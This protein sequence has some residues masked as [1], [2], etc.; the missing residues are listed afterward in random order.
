V[1][2][3]ANF[4]LLPAGFTFNPG[5]KLADKHMSRLL[6]ERMRHLPWAD[7]PGFVSVPN[8]AAYSPLFYL[9]AAAGLGAGRAA[10]LL[11]YDAIL[12]A[13]LVNALMFVAAGTVAL[14]LARRGRRLMFVALTLP[15]TLSLAASVNQDGLVIASSVLAA[16]LLSRGPRHGRSWWL[17]CVALAA[18]IL[19][20]P[21]YL[22]VAA[23]CAV[24]AW[25]TAPGRR[26]QIR[27][28]G[29]LLV[30]ALPALVWTAIVTRW[31]AAP[32]VRGPA[33]PAGPLWSGPA[34]T[35]FPTTNPGEQ[36]GILLAHPRLFGTLPFETLAGDLRWFG[37]STLGILG[38]LDWV[39]PEWMY[40]AWGLAVL[41]AL[42]ADGLGTPDE[43][44][45]LPLW[46]A[47]LLAGLVGIAAWAVFI[48]QYLS[49]TRVGEALIDGVQGRYALP[50]VA[51]LALAVPRVRVQGGAMLRRGLTV[52]PVGMALLDAVALPVLTVWTYWMY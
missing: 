24:L 7:G 49:W 37:L 41:V 1:G 13:R 30:A 52:V 2:V 26:T 12:V 43:A 18:V 11:P 44:P 28:A 46:R 40:L 4:G 10:G 5:L 21:P 17:G 16:A 45:G 9:P 31:V 22:P 34:G 19:A 6:W 48:A 39:L 25:G 14:L 8:T 38:V 29:G 51:M 32:F 35:M 3:Q 27:A 33:R 20:K 50:L 36:L 15:M 47:A 23:A 42:L